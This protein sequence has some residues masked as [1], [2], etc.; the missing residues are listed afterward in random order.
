[1]NNIINRR[2]SYGI[3]LGLL[4]L[5]PSLSFSCKKKQ[6]AP[7]S[8]S[9]FTVSSAQVVFESEGSSSNVSITANGNWTASSNSSSIWFTIS[10]ASGGSGNVTLKLT[11][12][13]NNTGAGREAIVTINASNGDT[14]QI[15]VS[16]PDNQNLLAKFAMVSPKLLTNNGNPLL[17]FMFTADPTAIEYNGR[18]YVYTTNDQQ[19]YDT[20]GPGGKNTYA[21]IRTLVMMSSAD[22][23]NWTYH[24]LI[25][26]AV[27]APWTASSWAPSIESRMEADGKTH[28]YMYY[29]NNGLGSAMLT[30][31]SPVGPWKDP[32][33][34]NIVDRSVPGVDVGAP[35]DPGVLIDNQGT[36]WLVF[37]GGTP[38]TKY[39]PDNARI[40]K[41]GADMISL[42]GNVSKIPAPYMNEASDLNF[43]NGTW[44]YNYCTNWDPRNVWPYSN[45]PKPTAC[46]ISYMTSKTPLDSGSWKYGDNYFRNPGDNVGDKIGPLTNNHSHLFT[47]QGKWYFAY[48]AMYLQNYFNTTGGFRNVGIEEAPMDTTN[49]V[50][51]PMI[52][53]TFKGPSQTKLL[54]PFV[55]QQA[56]TTAGTSGHVKFDTAG[57]VGNM[58]AIGQIDKQVLMVRGADFSK[59]IP[60]KFEARVKGTGQIDVYVNNLKGPALVSL[61]CDTKD[62]T[63]LSTQIT[64]KIPNG[65]GNI[66][67]VFY[68]DGFLFDDWQFE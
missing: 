10:Q 66:Y 30:S 56:E 17:D 46:N 1:M 3:F 40:V 12:N 36:G 26:T 15:Q 59:Q 18:V 34:K 50:N 58:V 33:G 6:V 54:N 28:F 44:V 4:F 41:L 2:K 14:R 27:L 25:N 45:I 53:A 9:Q 7:Q 62:W 47:F 42:A 24:G 65:V 5:F 20:V 19:Q 63:T 64:Q 52:N 61:K 39:M 8:Q 51:I 67:F 38:K 23:V 21:Y 55:L 13:A 49:G 60:S 31:T 37:G 35:F 68:G 16:Q 11:A 32:L 29:S 48:H 22:M 57:I 43:I